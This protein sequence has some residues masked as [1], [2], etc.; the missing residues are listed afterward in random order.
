MNKYKRLIS[1]TGIVFFGNIGT[2]LLQFIL[3]P[4][5]TRWMDPEAYGTADLI[6][7]YSTIVLGFMSCQI[8]DSI[9]LFP[10]GK[11]FPVQKKYFSSGVIFSVA[12][13]VVFLGVTELCNLAF[14]FFKLDNTIS[15]YSW[16]IYSYTI[17]TLFQNYTQQFCRSID[18]M[19][20]YSLSG[21]LI[22]VSM[23]V[24]AF[25][26]VR[27][28]ALKGYVIAMFLSQLIGIL[29][30]IF[31]AK[32]YR[33]F[34]FRSFDRN[35]L[36]H[37]L[38]YSIPLI[39]TT[40]MWWIIYSCNRPLLEKYC[41]VGEIGLFVVANKFPTLIAT[42]YTIFGNAWQI[43]VVEEFRSKQYK[44]YFNQIFDLFFLVMMGTAV[45]MTVFSKLLI[46]IF[47]DEAYHS[48]W[49]YM[50]VLALGIVFS[51]LSGFIATN[52]TA[53]KKSSYFLYSAGFAIIFA[54]VLNFI[55]IPKIGVWGAA[56]SIFIS[57]LVLLVV[58]CIF[59]AK[60]VTITGVFPKMLI[61]AAETGL[62]FWILCS[63]NRVPATVFG[64]GLIV[65]L[66][67]MFI[68]KALTIYPLKNI[69]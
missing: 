24:F 15:N 52:F 4:L 5:Y 64:V 43:S 60:Y 36:V 37:M 9:F 11:S 21:F 48:S 50:P 42:L 12:M 31:A 18:K 8:Q 59:A 63:E 28:Q 1:N 10:N 49:V 35:Y 51:N 68:R 2:K 6:M 55:L 19:V 40:L 58:R 17:F 54:I 66:G 7:V 46:S 62:I 27:T 47:T 45:C 44:E 3:L 41:G 14:S 65:I 25:T 38:K 22:T 13:I 32:L 23:V 57:L 34:S 39:P 26:L 69:F 20:V 16:I 33:F 61:I 30:S 56:I 67:V 29:F 53:A